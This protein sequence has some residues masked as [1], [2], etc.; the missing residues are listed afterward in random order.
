MKSSNLY[1][2]HEISI[3]KGTEGDTWVF[4]FNTLEEAN[5]FAEWHYN[6][7]LTEYEQKRRR[8]RVFEQRMDGDLDVPDGAFDS[9]E[10]KR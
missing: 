4:V 10:V 7:R 2:V 1:E 8:V 3:Y 6:R 9:D 5:E